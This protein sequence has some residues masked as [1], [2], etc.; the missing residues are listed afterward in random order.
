MTYVIKISTVILNVNFLFAI[1]QIKGSNSVSGKTEVETLEEA[2][3]SRLLNI[4][5]GSAE[6]QV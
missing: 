6:N 5:V 1:L 4:G 2:T 3:N